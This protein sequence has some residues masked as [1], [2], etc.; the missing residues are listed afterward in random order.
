MHKITC[1]SDQYCYTRLQ[2]IVP[3]D[4]YLD[5]KD[6]QA[7]RVLCGKNLPP[8]RWASAEKSVGIHSKSAISATGLFAFVSVIIYKLNY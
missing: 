5:G 7:C 3:F 6:L 1:S 2:P 8:T 4:V